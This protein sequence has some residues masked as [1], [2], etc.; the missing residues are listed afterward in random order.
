MV[1]GVGRTARGPARDG[2]QLRAGSRPRRARQLL[3][4][5]P[6]APGR[7]Q[8]ERREE[9]RLGPITFR[10]LATRR[11]NPSYMQPLMDQKANALFLRG[12]GSVVGVTDVRATAS[13]D[14]DRRRRI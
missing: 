2:A 3:R 9:R 10:R 13:A 6:Q 8:E 14:L 4:A 11:R 5:G 12:V 7:D 1:R